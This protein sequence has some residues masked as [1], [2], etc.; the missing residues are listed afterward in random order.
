MRN[1]LKSFAASAVLGIAALFALHF[2]APLT[3]V[4]MQVAPLSL[5]VSGLLGL[6][7]VTLLVLFQML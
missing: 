1:R 5:A 4:A 2:L 7:G 3:G 6:P